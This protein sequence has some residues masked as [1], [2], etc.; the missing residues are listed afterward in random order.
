MKATQIKPMGN[1]VLVRDHDAP[2]MTAGGLA[3]PQTT[4]DRVLKIGGKTHRFAQV[5]AIGPGAGEHSGIMVTREIG[6]KQEPLNKIAQRAMIRP[7]DI[8][9][10]AG[11][12]VV[13]ID[14]FGHDIAVD[15]PGTH[16][17]ILAGAVEAEIQGELNEAPQD[18]KEPPRIF[19]TPTPTEARWE[20]PVERD[21]AR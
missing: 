12:T 6:T 17:M 2:T 5:I 11:A 9:L 16:R 15:E 21:P 19:S 7:Q 1:Y 18:F 20:V 8:G 10:R 4:M 14:G 13:Y 3:L